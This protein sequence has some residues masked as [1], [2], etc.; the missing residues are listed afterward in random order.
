MVPSVLDHVRCGIDVFKRIRRR[1]RSGARETSAVIV[2]RT[3][4]RSAQDA[5]SATPAMRHPAAYARKRRPGEEVP[6]PPTSALPCFTAA[7]RGMV[8]TTPPDRSH[9]RRPGRG[10]R[11]D[12]ERRPPHH[13]CR[14][15]HHRRRVLGPVHAAQAAQRDGPDGAGVR[16]RR[17]CR[18]DVVLEP[19]PGRAQRLRQLRLR[20]HLRRGAVAG[21]AVERALPRAARDPRLPGARRRSGSTCTATSLSTPGSPAHLRRGHRPL[22]GRRPTRG[23]D[24][25]ARYLI[26]AVGA[27]SVPNTPAVPGVDSFRRRDLPHRPVAAREGRLHRQAGRRHRHRRER[28]AG[29]PADREGGRRPH[30]LPAHRQLRPPGQ[31]RARPRGGQAGAARRLRGH[32]GAHPAVVRSA[33]S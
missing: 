25:S 22:D 6:G 26:A 4:G 15:G 32:P 28:G 33:S 24:V 16:G 5:G 29:H 31:Q 9:G 8:H 2:S 14:R 30:R 23:E 17:R 11:H 12:S 3:G 18:R 7:G 27:L 21:M 10:D 1:R 20:L 13:R 19:L